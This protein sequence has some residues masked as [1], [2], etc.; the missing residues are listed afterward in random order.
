MPVM[1][2]AE[3]FH[4]PGA[5]DNQVGIVLCHGFTGTT[6]SMR[7]WGEALAAEG[8]A[9]HGPR[10]PGHGTSW[11]EAN[12]TRWTDWYAELERAFDDLRTTH[13]YVVV[14]GLSMGGTL[15][16][17]LAEE[18]AGEVNGIVLVNPSLLTLRK[19]ARLLPVASKFL[20]SF[21]PIAGDIKKPGVPE[22]GYDRLPV[23]AAASM[24]QLWKV[25]RADL[26]RI[27][28]PVLLYRSA[29][30]HVVEAASSAALVRGAT[31]TVVEEHVL[32][33]SYHVATLDNDA[34]QIFVGS[35]RFV[36]SLVAGLA[37]TGRPG[38]AP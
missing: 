18:R 6:A 15:T 12:L 9:V 25:A 22:L 29:V 34:P 8:F 16:I 36:R 35:A 2:G 14:M 28:A 1:S 11:Q 33:D 20:S 10:L 4:F 32:H 38:G 7:P 26:A 24:A 27:T 5:A 21:P 23:K 17:R 31:S 30:D 37:A 19:D 13:P 3:P